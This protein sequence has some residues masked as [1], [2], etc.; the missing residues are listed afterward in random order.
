MTEPA[1]GVL[2]RPPASAPLGPSPGATGAARVGASR[3]RSGGGRGG[4]GRRVRHPRPHWLPVLIPAD[5]EPAPDTEDHA[6]A[7][8]PGEQITLTEQAQKNLHLTT[9]PL[10]PVTFWKTIT[11][12]GMVIDRPGHGDRGVVAPATSVVGTIHHVA[13]D[14]VRPGDIL[15]TLRLLSE[16]LQ[17]TQTDLFKTA[18]DAKIARAPAAAAR[19]GRRGRPGGQ[20]DRGG[21]PGDAV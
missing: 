20:A 2:D 6:A 8:G 11:V 17:L 21:Q 18:Q 13:G 3:R 1:A 7:E 12:P 5:Q 4:R 15:F 10:T 9:E 16:A 14:T 19:V